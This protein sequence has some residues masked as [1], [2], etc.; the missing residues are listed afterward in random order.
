MGHRGRNVARACVLAVALAAAPSAHALGPCPGGDRPARALLSGKGA[1]ESVIVD[2]GG[3]LFY[4]DTSAKALMR[5]DHRGAQPAAILTGV[6][7]IAGLVFDGDGKLLVGYGSGF[8]SG[9]IGNVQPAAGVLKVDPNTGARSTYATGLSMANGLARSLDGSV[10]ASDDVGLGI[11]RIRNG[12]VE[13]QRFRALSSN[14]L[15]VS[16]NGRWLF[17]SQTF[18]PAA[19][20]AIRLGGPQEGNH[21]AA[22]VSAPQDWTAGLDGMDIDPASGDLYVTANGITGQLWRVTP[23]KSACRYARGLDLLLASAVAVGRGS[24]P[25][26]FNAANIYVV[27]FAGKLLE[28]PRR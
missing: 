23:F 2:A 5:V 7:G 24:D 27:T 18:L 4:T 6:E 12:V 22:F 21:A 19:V 15:A 20:R 3:R 13:H 1:L 9:L 25:A 26:R 11:D 14:G 16:R 8:Q 28:L 10:Y 17:F